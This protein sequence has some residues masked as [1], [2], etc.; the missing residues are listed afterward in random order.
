MTSNEMDYKKYLAL[1]KKSKVL[2]IVSALAI[3]TVV[4]ATSY[5]LPNVY[6]AQSTVFIEKSVIAD[7]V[8]GLAFTP[9]VEEKIKA[10]TYALNSRT[11]IAKVIDELDLKKGG[12]AEQE[13]L[14]KSLQEH[15]QIKIKDK[16]GLFMISFKDNNPKLARDYVNA[17]VRRYIDENTSSKREES[18]GATQF[19]SEQM[20]VFREKLQ[21]SEE[22][23]NAFKRG[24]GAVASM[25]PT[26]LLKDINDSQQRA[27]DL[28]IKQAQLE[29]VIASLA[30]DSPLQSNLPALQKRL[31]EL[32]L[33]YTDK[34]PDIVQLKEDIRALEEQQKSGQGNRRPVE[35]LEYKRSVSELKAMRQAEANLRANIA[36]NRALL[37][38]IPAAKSALEDLERE[39]NAQKTLYETMAA[40]QGQS[41]V[42]KQ[43]EVQDKST[44]FRIVDPAV[45]PIKP[46][47][48]D[49]VRLILFGIL[50]GI[51]GGVGLVILKDQMDN[52]VKNIDMAARFGLPVLAVI[53]KIEDPQQIVVQARKDRRLYMISGLY[54]SMIIAVLALE[55]LGVAVISNVMSRFSS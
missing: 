12:G 14:I 46:V 33:Q 31:Q 21:K 47:S 45:Q 54:F 35:S 37:Q 48:P 20:N 44:V 22:A 25:D 7:L 32:Q 6:E 3:M 55:V 18:Y 42:S 49:R 26:S 13:K 15:T 10:L 34:Y 36:R 2:C 19:L 39:K 23:A 28:N 1:V 52:S 51:G 16:E 53:P 4:T 30:K 27:D 11:L 41:E 5:V 8:K 29:T 24:P 50:A 17:L 9:T 43:M 40:R 38:S